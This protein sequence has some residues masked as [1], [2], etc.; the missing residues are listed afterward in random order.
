M[1]PQS[2]N[3]RLEG[4]GQRLDGLT[5]AGQRIYS[6]MVELLGRAGLDYN[7][8]V[9]DAGRFN[10]HYLEYGSGPTVILLHGAGAGS[11]IWFR[12]I[13]AL[14]KR[15]RVIAP[16]NPVFGLSTQPQHRVTVEDITTGYLLPFMDALGIESA[17]LAGLSLGGFLASLTAAHYPERVEDLVLIDS[18]GL[19]YH[20]PWV[21]RLTSLPFLSQF[22]SKPHRRAHYRFFS[23][24]EVLHPDSPHLE[25]FFEY[26]YQVTTNDGHSVALRKSVPSFANLRGQRQ[27]L[28][29]EELAGIRSRT[30]IIWGDSDRFFP[31]SH[32]ERAA[33]LIPGSRLEVL[34][35]C[36]HV[37]VLD[38]PDEVSGLMADFL[39][40]RSVAEPVTGS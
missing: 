25:A 32:G 38:R 33:R 7:G 18:A 39:D 2:S 12:Q 37:A 1:R 22:L 31:V 10:I 14:S 3:G 9:V 21:F 16:D 24:V 15:Y 6:S 11:A 29:G 4:A 20:L 19:G 17:S 27:V 40:S 34:P 36:G 30:L 26:A 5:P 35:Q 13:A 8:A 28:K 23:D